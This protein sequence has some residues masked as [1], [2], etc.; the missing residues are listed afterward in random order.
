MRHRCKRLATIKRMI[1]NRSSARRAF[2]RTCAPLVLA[3]HD[4]AQASV[5][6]PHRTVP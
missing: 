3:A 6:N 1:E 5:K 2:A 4:T